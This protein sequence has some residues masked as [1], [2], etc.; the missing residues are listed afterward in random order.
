M[1]KDLMSRRVLTLALAAGLI[2]SSASAQSVGVYRGASGA[3]DASMASADSVL[4]ATPVEALSRN[5]AGLTSVDA[6][7]FDVAFATLSARGRF[8][9]RVD[10]NGSLSDASGM[11]P[12]GAIAFPFR[13]RSLVVAGGLLTEGALAGSWSYKDAPGA[14]GPTLR[15]TH[16]L[17]TRESTGGMTICRRT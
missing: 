17:S 13:N 8:T 9:N 3:R 10:S 12:D 6:P 16:R 4:G 5:P 14:A 11:V 15:A 2:A 1:Q 7:E